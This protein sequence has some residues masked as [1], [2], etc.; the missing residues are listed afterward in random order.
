MSMYRVQQRKRKRRSILSNLVST[1]VVYEN[2]RA[3]TVDEEARSD[4]IL[5]SEVTK[6][7][8]EVQVPIKNSRSTAEQTT[9]TN[10]SYPK[11][12][13]IPTRDSEDTAGGD[14]SKQVAK[15][16]HLFDNIPKMFLEKL[17]NFTLFQNAP[18]AFYVEIARRLTLMIYNA[19]DYIVKAGESARAM[20]WILRGSVNI[21]SPDGEA[22]YAELLEG[23]YFGEIG[24]LFN[25][26]RTA[27]VVARTK[28]LVGV[29]TVE[30]F[31]QV[32]PSFPTVERQI[33]DE[34]Q[35]RLAMQ[36]KKQKAGV[37]NLLNT[38]VT[39]SNSEQ[40]S[41][42]P[43]DKS[44][45]N[46]H[47]ATVSPLLASISMENIDDSISIRQFLK[48]LPLF[49]TLP[50]DIIHG[51]ALCIEI[52]QVEAFEYIFR[53]NDIGND[54]Y[55]IVSGEVEV[56]SPK[57]S[58]EVSMATSMTVND[59]EILLARLGP[60]QYFGEMGFLSSISEDKRQ[61]VRSADIRSVSNCTL[62][63]LT[64]ETLREF[65]R[66]YPLVKREIKKTAEE[67]IKKN[68]DISGER[69]SSAPLKRKLSVA[70][71]PLC[72]N[73]ITLTDSYD[74]KT[75][76]P[77]IMR[78]S[79]STS[80]SDINSNI[81]IQGTGLNTP[82]SSISFNPN[83]SFNVPKNRPPSPLLP[84]PRVS[85]SADLLTSPQLQPSETKVTL[86]HI[87]SDAEIPLELQPPP[88]NCGRQYRNSFSIQNPAPVN[89]M[90]HHKRVR[91][92]SISGGPRRRP[93]V[94]TVGPL[95]D[96]ILLRCFH[97]LS[98]PELMKLRLVCRRW[99]QLLYVAP[100]L[101]DKL[102]LTLW[103]KTIDDKSLIQITDFVGSRPKLIDI[104]N[105]YHVTDE[106][107]S[108]MIN[109]IGI[110][111]QLR[112]IKMKGCW[113]V[114]AMAI[115][116]IAVPCIGNLL[117]EIDL[118]NCRNVRDDVIQRLIGWDNEPNNSVADQKCL[119]QQHE[120]W[121][122][123]LDD[124][125]PG[126]ELFDSSDVSSKVG[127]G[128]RNLKSLTLRYCK[129]LTDS[130]LYHLAL[131]TRGTLVC[132]DLTRCTGLTDVGFSYWGFQHFAKLQKLTLSEC[133][134]L[135]DNS[136]RS[137]ANCASNL[138]ELNLSFCCSLTDASIELLC[139]GCPL[140]ESLDLSFCGRAVSDVSSL[141]ISMHLRQ[142]RRIS[143]KGC[144][145]IT[146]S[147]VDSLL[148]GFAPLSFIDISQCKNAHMYQGVVAATKFEPAEG[149]RSVFVTME[150]NGDR[151]V[152]V[153][154]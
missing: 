58:I 101:F 53:K 72:T 95:P 28:V 68:S 2:T 83:F 40:T 37:I 36:E 96:R 130:T 122:Y 70:Q 24:L 67:R 113:E 75:S 144:L 20:Y 150:D 146:R 29:L 78:D 49:T 7:Q 116:D 4:N 77:S 121:L 109:E 108:Y 59:M 143:L 46:R 98:L 91:L 34:A 5:A 33:R 133:I 43:G 137:I 1:G 120:G 66:R 89:Y 55:F 6:E 44:V 54:I 60:G 9:V 23:S 25:R 103:N 22:V 148:G 39:P 71:E 93:S 118:T 129:G 30:N 27:T 117:E 86:K 31:N 82:F 111:G 112:T 15:Q 139:L 132:L 61:S 153:V 74:G 99:R 152:Q 11:N 126:M 97:Y 3:D 134:F 142:L 90:P 92:S 79:I 56:L 105:C 145:R 94:L 35:E 141:A 62:L 81:P 127:V 21:T 26:P 131:Y 151:C 115:M 48:S 51:L 19:Q 124:P 154:I 65:C 32:L 45:P 107:F 69:P 119:S 104:S 12:D 73:K 128:C 125:I 87:S 102:D 57:V 123:P 64:G 18:K 41:A 10:H 16:L 42:S 85:S 63:A 114:S 147:G 149:S 38:N 136:I 106:G 14:T 84:P 110:G 100:G 47:V 52:R 17:T 50:A 140:L 135:T 138:R 8:E 88:V 80:I 76:I 13:T